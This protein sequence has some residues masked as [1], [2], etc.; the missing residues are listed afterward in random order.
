MKTITIVSALFSLVVFHASIAAA[1]PDPVDKCV[2][3][4]ITASGKRFAAISKCRAKAVLAGAAV[5]SGCLDKA[6]SKFLAAF[7][8][9][10][11]RGAC[12]VTGD[13]AVIDDAVGGCAD[14]INDD[15]ARRCG[16]GVVT[17][18]EACDDGNTT[19]V[20]GCSATCEVE[21]GFD[22]TGAPSA[23]TS[24]CGDGIVASDEACDDG[25][26]SD[27]DGCSTSCAIESGYTCAGAPSACTAICG[28]GLIRGPETCDDG[29]TSG[30][31]G[32]SP[33]C[34]REGGWTCSG[35]PTVCACVIVADFQPAEGLKIAPQILQLY[36]GF[37][38]SGCGSLQYFWACQSDTS[39]ECP[40]FIAA[41]NSDGN[42]NAAPTLILQEHDVFEISLTVCLAG[43]S[44]CAPQILHVYEGISS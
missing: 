29:G 42:T 4:K 37:S 16:D 19:G 17:A 26:Q 11:L 24:T 9:A 15:L 40:N 14:T 36:A 38:V 43:T 7:A 34:D 12:T 23:C 3:A 20:D 5:D 31:D 18:P 44:T 32:C 10:E 27:D 21:P 39:T 2:A 35:E 1:G 30:G 8:K 22:C 6:E 25:G 28:D 13:A 41:A 33:G